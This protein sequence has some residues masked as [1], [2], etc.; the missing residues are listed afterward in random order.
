VGEDISTVPKK[1]FPKTA[2]VIG[3]SN[4]GESNDLDN[5]RNDAGAV[6]D[7]L[8][9]LGFKV[10]LLLDQN[11]QDMQMAIEEFGQRLNESQGTDI[12]LFY[13]S[14]HSTYQG[15]TNYL[16]PINDSKIDGNNLD[17]KAVSDKAILAQMDHYNRNGTN[18]FILDTCHDGSHSGLKTKSLTKTGL[19]PRFFSSS[20]MAIIFANTSGEIQPCRRDG[21]YSLYTE[22]LLE[23]LDE[24]SDKSLKEMFGEAH[25][26]VLMASEGKQRPFYLFGSMNNDIC[27]GTCTPDKHNLRKPAQV[28]NDVCLGACM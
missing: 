28:K 11:S 18:I 3:N 25:K 8:E 26:L 24:A 12:G 22:K 1:D 6:A 20:N 10:S 13:Y 9:E 2:L 5:P 15:D 17:D 4:Y 14:G 7:K 27:F 19:D 16:V 23:V 21:D